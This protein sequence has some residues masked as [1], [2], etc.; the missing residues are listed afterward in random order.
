MLKYTLIILLIFS[1][2]YCEEDY[3][4]RFSTRS[5]LNVHN[6]YDSEKK[7][8]VFLENNSPIKPMLASLILPGLGQIINDSPIWKTAMFVGIEIAG[9]AGY[10]TWTKHADDITKEYQDWADEHWDMSRWV[11][12][13]PIL[14]NAIQTSGYPSVDD[15]IIDGSHHITIIVDG[16]YQSSDILADN[17]NIDYTEVR[18]W[19]FYEGIGKYDQFVAGWDDALTNWDI[20]YKEISNNTSELIVMTPNKKHYLNLRN[21]S[22]VLYRNAKFAL[23]AVVFNHIFSALDILWSANKKRELSY[24]INV[25]KQ[26]DNIYVI[27]GISIEWKL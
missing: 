13:T 20:E 5:D 21:D 1:T 18:D 4:N 27:E 8:V 14:L 12:N 3:I 11:T 6:L 16:I 17:P 2:L 19:D 22:N 9:I 23:T 7:S 25:S 10:I 15:V 24:K 26:I